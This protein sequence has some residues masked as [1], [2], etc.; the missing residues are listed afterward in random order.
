MNYECGKCDLEKMAVKAI[1]TDPIYYQKHLF[2]KV[3]KGLIKYVER[4]VL[5]IDLA[6]SRAIE[7]GYS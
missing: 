4:V 3:R 5:L 7:N 1:A 2:F 6:A